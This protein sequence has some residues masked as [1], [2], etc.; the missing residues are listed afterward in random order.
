MQKSLTWIV[1]VLIVL[2][3]G[4]GLYMMTTAPGE[5]QNTDT[6]IETD[7]NG[8]AGT[9]ET[10]TD[11]SFDDTPGSGIN[12]TPSVKTF[13]TAEV[14]THNSE[15][16]CWA[17]IRGGVYDLTAWIGSHPGGER[18]ILGLCGKDGTSAFDKQH[19]GSGRPEDT[20]TSF[21]IGVLAQ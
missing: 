9:V 4:Y 15:S 8:A 13:T 16:S 19:G 10:G 7:A 20:L 1:I 11:S 6:V 18:A 21:K 17:I 14:A 3:G 12:T 2:G 5:T